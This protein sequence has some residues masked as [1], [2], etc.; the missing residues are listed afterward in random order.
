MAHYKKEIYKVVSSI[1]K[2]EGSV[3]QCGY[4][5]FLAVLL[6]VCCACATDAWKRSGHTGLAK[7]PVPS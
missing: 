5:L 4:T 6:S 3:V 2:Y 1:H 7:C